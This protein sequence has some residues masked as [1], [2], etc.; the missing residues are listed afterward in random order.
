MFEVIF[1]KVWKVMEEFFNLMGV[2][3][4]Y[5]YVDVEEVLK[6]EIMCI[7][8]WDNFWIRFWRGEVLG[9]DIEIVWIL[10]FLG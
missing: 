5:L 2:I 8:R 3:R 1:N 10:F 9:V 7:E 6:S 4:D